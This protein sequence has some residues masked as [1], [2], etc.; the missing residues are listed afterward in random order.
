V[1]EPVDTAPFGPGSI[2]LRLYP[3][4][5]LDAPA[6]VDELRVQA[7][8]AVA[9]GFD[10]VMTSEHHG[11]F[12]GY[13]PNPLQAAG[14]CLDA[15]PSGWAAPAPLLLP[16]RPPALVAEEVAWLA[17]RFPGRVGLG[18][19]S[20]ALRGDFEVMGLTMERLSERF[21][22]ALEIVAGMLS[23]RAPGGLAGDAAID[24]CAQHPVPMVSAAM[25]FTAV[26]RA[27]A[28]GVGLLFDSL[29]T[30]ERCR[31]LTDAYRAAGGRG[32]CVLIRRAWLGA[33]PRERLDDQVD[34]YRSYTPAAAQAA[35]GADELVDAD[36]A[37]AV[38]DGLRD[39]VERAGCDALNL[40]VH[41]PGVDPDEVRVQIEGLGATVLPLLRSAVSWSGPSER[42]DRRGSTP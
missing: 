23:G 25:G 33:P 37:A 9:H 10:G 17:A 26:R 41:V 14:F 42:R 27:A 3:H 12:H 11:G 8:L 39:A 22:A 5:D 4:N 40:R 19:A 24:A 34:V 20:G 2:S 38:A 1:T 21:G 7:A 6:I 29:S 18:V 28:N 36:D 15:M 16:L 31:E 30:P 35:W 32:S 13:L